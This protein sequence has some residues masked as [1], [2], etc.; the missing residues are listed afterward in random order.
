MQN[1]IHFW[2]SAVQDLGQGAATEKP[3]HSDDSMT[4]PQLHLYRLCTELRAALICCTCTACH[5]PC[6]ARHYI[7]HWY[8]DTSFAC[9]DRLASGLLTGHSWQ[10]CIQHIHSAQAVHVQLLLMPLC[11]SLHV[12]SGQQSGRF[13]LVAR[14]YASDYAESEEM[15]RC[16]RQVEGLTCCSW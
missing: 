11:L 15:M 4:T 3:K 14:D 6:D 8:W 16:P 5:Y 13:F 7:L 9:R 12:L 1:P 2:C 10:Q